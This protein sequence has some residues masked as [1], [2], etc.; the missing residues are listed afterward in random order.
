[1]CIIEAA[2]IGTAASASASA[3]ASAAAIAAMAN[4][5][6]ASAVIGV[7]GAGV[8]FYGQQQQAAYQERSAN[9][10]YQVQMANRASAEAAQQRQFEITSQEATDAAEMG[11]AIDGIAAL[12]AAGDRKGALARL[13]ALVPEFEHETNGRAP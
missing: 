7:V 9:Y 8:G 13:N 2:A 3:A 6:I 5:A 10:Q 12:A 1:M 11:A 4:A